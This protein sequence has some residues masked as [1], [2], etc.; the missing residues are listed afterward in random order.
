[1]M[2]NFQKKGLVLLGAVG[3]VFILFMWQTKQQAVQ[4][5]VKLDTNVKSE[6]RKGKLKVAE[7]N[8]QKKTIMIDIKGAVHREGVYEVGAGARVKDGIEKAGGFL[9]EA[10]MEKVNLAQLMQD[11]M[12]LY[13]PK[14]GE[15]VQ[16]ANLPSGRQEEKIQI[17]VA[18]KEQLEK[19]TGIG[20]RKAENILK[21]REEH[22]PFQKMEDLLEVDGIGEKSLEKIKDKIIIP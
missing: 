16:G 10:D 12:L 7:S 14:K 19:I 1:M 8:E 5:T 18:S 20:P 17:N 6:E 15:Q 21:Y 9:P 2:Q 3:V 4:P 11:Q 22:G 13:V